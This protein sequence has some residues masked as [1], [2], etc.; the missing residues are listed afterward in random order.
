M[1]KIANFEELDKRISMAEHDDDASEGEIDMSG[2]EGIDDDDDDDDD[3]GDDTDDED[4]SVKPVSKKQNGKKASRAKD[5]KAVRSNAKKRLAKKPTRIEYET[6]SNSS[7][8]KQKNSASGGGGKKI[9][10]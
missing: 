8:N 2:D 9:R 4:N 5:L 7:K 3:L 1:F 6:E 10:F